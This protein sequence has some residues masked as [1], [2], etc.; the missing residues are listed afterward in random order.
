MFEEHEA[1]DPV[2]KHVSNCS[3]VKVSEVGKGKGREGKEVGDFSK[4]S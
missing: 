1:F 4:E 3:E 2:V